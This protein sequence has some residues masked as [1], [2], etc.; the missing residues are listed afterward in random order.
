LIASKE[1]KSRTV[2]FVRSQ[3]TIPSFFEVAGLCKNFGGIQ[4]LNSVTLCIEE[5]KIISL[6]GPNGAGKT[7][8]INVVT[9][10]F[11]PDKGEI[12]FQGENIAG[13]SPH[14]IASKGIGRTF[15]FEE[16]FSS[17]SVLENV[18]V[19]CH[20]RT[21]SGILGCGF[22]ISSVRKEEKRIRDEAME[23]LRLI[24]LEK[25][26]LYSISA[27]P[28]GER[29]LVGIARALAMKPKFLLLDEPVGGLAA[30]EIEK[31]VN[32]LF[33]LLEKGL[34][35]LIVEHNMPFVMAISHRVIVLDGGAKIAEGFPDEVK[36]NEKV[37]E[38]YLGKE[39][40]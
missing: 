30:H 3:P 1:Q 31:L 17:M 15:Q 26:S 10:I 35:L 12:Y 24:G 22:Q 36:S 14:L 19:G 27:L 20:A 40:S 21:R 7:T 23:D 25:K 39:V 33:M 5:G 9:G 6:I 18:M 2:H 11:P 34:T 38:A 13:L 4:A 32:L 16:L 8:F 29:K 37:I 28:L